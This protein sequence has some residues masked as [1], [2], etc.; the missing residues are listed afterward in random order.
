VAL[1]HFEVER[2][3]DFLRFSPGAGAVRAASTAT[4]LT[5]PEIDD[6]YHIHK[7]TEQL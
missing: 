2:A 3:D 5:S 7:F 1:Q 4:E 6:Q